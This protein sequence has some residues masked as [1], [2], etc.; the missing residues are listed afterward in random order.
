M[1]AV[2]KLDRERGSAGGVG[3]LA[4]E[5]VGDGGI[6]TARSLGRSRGMGAA[7]LERATPSV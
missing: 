5:T 6:G 1:A 2:G 3:E 4:I 7:R